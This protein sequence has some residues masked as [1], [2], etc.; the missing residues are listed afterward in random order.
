MLEHSTPLRSLESQGRPFGTGRSPG[1]PFTS[2]PRARREG[3]E[4]EAESTQPGGRRRARAEKDASRTERRERQW[5]EEQT[6]GTRREERA[7]Q[8]EAR[9]TERV[10]ARRDAKTG[11]GRS[12]RGPA[13]GAERPASFEALPNRGTAGE[14]VRA[15][16][17]SGPLESG[18]TA[19]HAAPEGALPE[20]DGSTHAIFTQAA[21]AVIERAA[22]PQ[23]AARSAGITSA[24]AGATPG[25]NTAG[26]RSQAPTPQ[27]A[28]GLAP[29]Q[30]ANTETKATRTEA[31]EPLPAPPENERAAEVMRQFRMQLHPGLKSAMIELAPAELGR[32]RI[33]MKLD[34]DQLRAVVRAEKPEALAALEEHLPELRSALEQ[35]GLVADDLDLGLGF[36]GGHEAQ[37]GSF[38]GA[39]QPAAEAVEPEIDHDSLVRAVA[40]RSGVDFYA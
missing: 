23:L 33:E 15:A 26:V 28:A 11:S 20:V 34:G 36:D 2:A 30:D 9:S 10:E 6:R 24:T 29:A 27:G 14:P 37:T 8:E 22:N 1:N 40:R 3:R 25:S 5:L 21:P 12:A 18:G 4:A 32:I 35:Q 31:R 16:T 39:Q 13:Q 7:S 19:L 38:G 17:Q